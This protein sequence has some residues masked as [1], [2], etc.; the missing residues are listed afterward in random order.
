MAEDEG[1]AASFQLS[2]N[3]CRDNSPGF[4][5]NPGA[6]AKGGVGDQTVERV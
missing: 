6:P 5:F 2:N 3:A 1:P 4:V